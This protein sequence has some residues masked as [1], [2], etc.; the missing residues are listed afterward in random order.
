LDKRDVLRVILSE[1]KDPFGKIL[2]YTAS[3]YAYDDVVNHFGG[4][5]DIKNLLKDMHIEGSIK[6]EF[7]HNKAPIVLEA[8]P[9]AAELLIAES[10]RSIGF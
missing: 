10:R 1:D 8:T 5:D 6:I 3:R 2:G 4:G 9:Y 7:N